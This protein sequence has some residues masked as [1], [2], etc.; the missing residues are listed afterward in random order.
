MHTD[1]F[2]FDPTHKIFLATNALP[3]IRENDHAIWRRIY[4]IHFKVT[5]PEKEQDKDL[6]EKLKEELPGILTWAVRGC[7]E[8]QRNGLQPPKEVL[9]DTQQYREDE[10]QL[11]R[12]LNECCSTGPRKR[13]GSTDLYKKYA[14]WCNQCGEDPIYNKN[15]MGR[16]LRALGYDSIKS[17]GNMYRKGIAL[18]ESSP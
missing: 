10:N 1:E 5:I 6:S 16:A 3:A 2:V 17:N 11:Q 9:E 12:F 4:C 7:M 13:V 15:T 8:W 18:E 14:E